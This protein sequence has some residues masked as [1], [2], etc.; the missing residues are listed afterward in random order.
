MFPQPIEAAQIIVTAQEVPLT[1]KFCVFLSARPEIRKMFR[2]GA[3]GFQAAL[4]RLFQDDFSSLRS[5]RGGESEPKSSKFE[6]FN[7]ELFSKMAD[8]I[9]MVLSI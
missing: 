2:S 3:G 1:P 8:A 5:L 9:L 4:G 7:F 6:K